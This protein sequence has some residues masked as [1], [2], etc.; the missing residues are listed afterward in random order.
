M[1]VPI[2]PGAMVLCAMKSAS[3]EDVGMAGAQPTPRHDEGR[4]RPS[5][6]R[7]LRRWRHPRRG[8]RESRP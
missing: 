1:G 2:R 5:L 8:R 6:P 3:C 4:R 7:R